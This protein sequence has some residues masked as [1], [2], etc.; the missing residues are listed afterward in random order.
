M[1][2][3]GQT[4]HHAAKSYSL[5]SCCPIANTMPISK[6]RVAHTKRCGTNMKNYRPPS[7]TSR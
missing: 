3:T 1:G 4:I 2:I 6:S 7:I 5:T